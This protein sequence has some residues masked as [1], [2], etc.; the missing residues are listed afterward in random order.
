MIPYKGMMYMHEW[1]GGTAV[2][3]YVLNCTLKINAFQLTH[4]MK[5]FL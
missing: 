3:V 1:T 5:I 4:I 2:C